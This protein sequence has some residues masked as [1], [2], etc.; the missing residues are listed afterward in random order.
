MLDEMIR[1]AFVVCEANEFVGLVPCHIRLLLLSLA[2]HKATEILSHAGADQPPG[3]LAACWQLQHKCNSPG[4]KL[5][6]LL[7][8]K[9]QGLGLC[10]DQATKTQ[11]THMT[12]AADVSMY[13]L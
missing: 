13:E 10:V 6:A 1:I 12:G 11:K 4:H 9:L 8:V 3:R 7:E 5:R 2:I